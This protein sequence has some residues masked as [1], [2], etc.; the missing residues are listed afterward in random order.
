VAI[1]SAGVG[2]D[3]TIYDFGNWIEAVKHQMVAQKIPSRIGVALNANI[4]HYERFL[5]YRL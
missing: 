1:A 5:Q 4:E 3:Q 2:F